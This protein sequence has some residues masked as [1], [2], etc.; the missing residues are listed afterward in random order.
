M[1]TRLLAPTAPLPVVGQWLGVCA[2]QARRTK[3]SGTQSFDFTTVH[4]A[5]VIEAVIANVKQ[6]TPIRAR[7]AAACGQRAQAPNADR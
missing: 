3:L 1:W 4:T 7:A 5:A 6:G 2:A